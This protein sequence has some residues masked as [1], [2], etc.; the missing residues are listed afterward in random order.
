[1]NVVEEVMTMPLSSV[2]KL[3]L[4]QIEVDHASRKMAIYRKIVEE[5]R[6]TI[7][8]LRQIRAR[9][10]RYCTIRR[11]VYARLEQEID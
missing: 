1:M 9:V 2:A 3:N 7:G 8:R 11:Q 10:A 4:L 6:A 5:E